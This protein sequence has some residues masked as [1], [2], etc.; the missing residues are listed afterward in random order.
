MLRDRADVAP[1]CTRME[2]SRLSGEVIPSRWRRAE[3]LVGSLDE[4]H[5]LEKLVCADSV[6]SDIEADS[7]QSWRVVPRC[8]VGFA[9]GSVAGPGVS[10]NRSVNGRQG[11]LA[12]K[13]RTRRGQSEGSKVQQL[14]R[15]G[16]TNGELQTW[17][18]VPRCL[19]G[20]AQGSGHCRP[21]RLAPWTWRAPGDLEAPDP[22][23][24][25]MCTRPEQGGTRRWALPNSDVEADVALG[26]CAP[27][28]PRSLTP[29]VR[30]TGVGWVCGTGR[31]CASG[32]RR[33]ARRPSA[34]P[35][36]LS[37]WARA[38]NCGHR[39]LVG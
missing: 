8:L 16:S 4:G 36:C 24:S 11:Q 33:F 26:R 30:R 1:G 27:S 38:A 35:S 31:L 23:R 18:A 15:T 20:F 21:R 17:R 13:R 14:E 25:P 39:T 22:E 32:Q 5:R 28:G 19:V 2:G 37:P 10:T 6:Q 34:R 3:L 12:L 9:Q 29:V 7:H